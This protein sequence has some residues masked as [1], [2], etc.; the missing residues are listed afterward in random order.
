MSPDA[1]RKR[2]ERPTQRTR[3]DAILN[4][5]S[6]GEYDDK[7][8]EIREAVQGRYDKKKAEVEALV[9]E[10]YGEDYAV[11]PKRDANVRVESSSPSAPL[12]EG[13]VDITDQLTSEALS[14]GVTIE[15]DGAPH[16]GPPEEDPNIESRSPIIGSIDA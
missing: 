10:V 15:G 7:L 2:P 3:I 8:V 12:P 1:P 13:F 6:K 4:A 16:T 14:A 5:I 9:K 11:V